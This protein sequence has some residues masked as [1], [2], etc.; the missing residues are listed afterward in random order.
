MTRIKNIKGGYMDSRIA[1]ALKEA[2]EL[3]PR[4]KAPALLGGL[5][6][7]GYLQ[8]LDSKG[9]GPRKI[10][11]GRRVVYLKLDLIEWLVARST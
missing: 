7:R 9:L 10:M 4:T 8:N 1:E 3:I 11:I 5:I 6:S 2:P